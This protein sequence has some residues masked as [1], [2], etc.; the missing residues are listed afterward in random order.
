MYSDVA[1]VHPL[2]IIIDGS[3]NVTQNDEKYI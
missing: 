2:Y 3:V 1:M